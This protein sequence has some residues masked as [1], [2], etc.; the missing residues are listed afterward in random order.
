MFAFSFVRLIAGIDR[1]GK[2]FLLDI[3][4][5]YS[6]FKKLIEIISKQRRDRTDF[7]TMVFRL[8]YANKASLASPN[9]LHI[10]NMITS[11][12]VPSVGSITEFGVDIDMLYEEICRKNGGK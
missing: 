11:M 8:L 12:A 10:W 5:E 9:G 2:R 7:D 4:D 6:A 1:F 3:L